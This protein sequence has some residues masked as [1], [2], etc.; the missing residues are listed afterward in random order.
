M[1]FLLYFSPTF[2]G[3][4]KRG[5]PI[6]ELGSENEGGQKKKDRGDL[7]EKLR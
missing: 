5:D 7:D 4:R 2:C 3:Q 1:C 6:K